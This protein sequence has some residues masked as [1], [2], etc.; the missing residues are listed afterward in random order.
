ML[1][2]PLPSMDTSTLTQAVILT[3]QGVSCKEA[4]R[5]LRIPNPTLA[6]WLARVRDCGGDV[7][8][9]MAAAEP[10]RPVLFSPNELETALARWYRCSKES[11]TT[12][13]WF[14][15]RD[16]RVRPEIAAVIHAIE[17]RALATGK[18][19]A[20][21]DSI[22][23]AFRVNAQERADFGGRK[24]AQQEEMVTRRG[25]FEILEDGSH[26]EIKPGETWELDDYSANQPFTFK[27]PVT[28]ELL[29]GRQVLAARDLSAA[30]WL[31][32]DHIGRER[33]AYRGEDIV[34]FIERLCRAWGLPRRLRLERG[35]WEGEAVHGIEVKGM[36]GRWGDLRDI[37]LIE[38]VY[39]SKSKGIVE[40]GFN[41]LQRWLAHSSTD[42]GRH[43]GDF[44]EA[45]KRLRQ[46]KS[47]GACPLAL[48]FLTDDASSHAHSEAAALINA[49]PMRREHLG[50][51]V[52][53]DDLV[54]RHGW[55]TAPFREELA[56]YFLPCK[57]QRTVRAGSVEVAPGN[58]WEKVRLYVNGVRDDVYFENGHQVLIAFDPARPDLGAHIC[59]GDL[60]AKNRAGWRMGQ[61]LLTGVVPLP[62]A[63]QF[64]AS[65]ILTPHMPVRKK[66]AA[67][68]TFRTIRA[69]A[70]THQPAATR[71]TV[72][73][74]GQGGRAAA[75]DIVRPLRSTPQAAP[76]VPSGIHFDRHAAPQ[77]PQAAAVH[78]DRASGAQLPQ[79]PA[80]AWSSRHVP[81]T[82]EARAA[83]IERLRQLQ[84]AAT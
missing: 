18:D 69:A 46:A 26:H 56:W 76:Q 62:L 15:A 3:S 35:A 43:R 75:S 82:R 81:A 39:K 66:A 80:A 68:T 53:P 61:V 58:G 83:E 29:V 73:V 20:W 5:Q 27:D 44:E 59:N 9:A 77:M 17:E 63:P 71:E 40:G 4:A 70:G 49:R 60:S 84:E 55:A 11:L 34:R 57:Q 21:P 16:A 41:V 78:F 67:S 32:F 38:H 19:E 52:A 74:D 10:G 13:A 22:R 6:R 64:N 24:H 42:I 25:M 7:E 2:L 65:G 33:D 50:E 47:T 8:A 12:A 28:G 14:F 45:T 36:S 79:A 30:K 72:V 1:P 37:M 54:A 23:R 48:G 51:K 31:G